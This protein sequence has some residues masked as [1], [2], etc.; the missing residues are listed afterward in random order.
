LEPDQLKARAKES[1]ENHG[2]LEQAA[3]EKM[4]SLLRYVDGDTPTRRLSPSSASN[5]ATPKLPFIIS[6]FR[7][8]VWYG[9]RRAGEK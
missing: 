1:L 5:S 4:L 8:L 7:Q 6:P 9:R 2:G 3:F